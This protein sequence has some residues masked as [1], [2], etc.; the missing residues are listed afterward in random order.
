MVTRKSA[1]TQRRRVARG[2]GPGREISPAAQA[3]EREADRALARYEERKRMDRSTSPFAWPEN[4][5]KRECYN[6]ILKHTRWSGKAVLEIVRTWKCQ[7]DT[8]T[9]HHNKFYWGLLAI[10]PQG[11]FIPDPALSKYAKEMLY[12]AKHNVPPEYLIGFL[13]QS[14]NLTF[15]RNQLRSGEID[16]EFAA[17]RRRTTSPPATDDT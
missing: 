1:A 4:L 5:L 6:L 11:D 2:R 17:F 12:A 9:Y 16:R 15:I 7:P 13:L 14:G 10:D 8:I 3:F